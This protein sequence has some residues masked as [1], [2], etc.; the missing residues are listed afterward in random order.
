MICR[1]EYN[2]NDNV[3][4][5]HNSN[6]YKAVIKERN[7]GWNDGSYSVFCN[8]LR[9]HDG[10]PVGSKNC[11]LYKH[12]I[13]S[14]DDAIKEDI[15]IINLRIYFETLAFFYNSSHGMLIDSDNIASKVIERLYLVFR[16]D[17]QIN[18]LSDN[19]SINFKNYMDYKIGETILLLNDTLVYQISKCCPRTTVLSFEGMTQ[20]LKKIMKK[21]YNFE[22]D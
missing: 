19:E 1:G 13:I 21:K 17:K 4:I 11:I 15:D 6:I 14:Y 9:S 2:L 8:N 18:L 16:L 3:I 7:V 12:Q 10:R 22:V 5:F 20:V